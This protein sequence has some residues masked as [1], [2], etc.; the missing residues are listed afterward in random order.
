[1]MSS[2]LKGLLLTGSL[3]A[4]LASSGIAGAQVT[5]RVFSEKKAL[6]GG[7]LVD[8][9]GG[10]SI[11]D[12]VILIDGNKII[13][14]GEEGNLAELGDCGFACGVHISYCMYA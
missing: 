3:L 10:A 9:L 6:I 5:D 1:M 7:T 13:D 2:I 12:S 8:G 4:A 11:Y 14:V